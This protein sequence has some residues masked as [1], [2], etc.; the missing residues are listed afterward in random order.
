MRAVGQ[1]TDE[2][3]HEFLRPVQ[4][5]KEF[6]EAGVRG[7]ESG[8]QQRGALVMSNRAPPGPPWGGQKEAKVRP[9]CTRAWWGSV[10]G[11]SKPLL[12]PVSKVCVAL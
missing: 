8:A 6:A 10:G 7:T 11:W 12:K 2:L 3:G 9:G 5:F 1:E 4:L